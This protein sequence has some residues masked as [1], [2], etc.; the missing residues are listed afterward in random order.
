MLLYGLIFIA[1]LLEGEVSLIIAGMLARNRNV[2]FADV[3]LL[4][5]IAVLLHDV[6]YYFIGKWIS[7]RNRPVVLGISKQRWDD[8][9]KHLKKREGIYIFV[10][11]F[12]WGMNRFVLIASGYYHTKFRRFLSY[13]AAAAFLW[14][15][16]FVSLGY[17]FAEKTQLLR[18]DMRS[19]AIVIAILFLGVI[20][21][22]MVITKKFRKEVH[23]TGDKIMERAKKP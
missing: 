16:T 7:K 23:L 5:F 11:K 14:V 6:V 17:M 19:I 2:D 8:F 3:F 18:K 10:S 20:S 22:E 21:I 9:L 4:A 1:T 15:V 13:S 12:A